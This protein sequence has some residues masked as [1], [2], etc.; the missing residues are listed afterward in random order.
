MPKRVPPKQ[1][2]NLPRYVA[3][4]TTPLK[5]PSLYSEEFR[6]M[7]NPDEA[8]RN[9]HLDYINSP[10]YKDRLRKQG[11]SDVNQVIHDRR[12]RVQNAVIVPQ[13][14]K[15][16]GSAYKS[17]L[18][19]I[20]IDPDQV[21]DL[22]T[23]RDDVL[24]HEMG[25]VTNSSVN[26][27]FDPNYR[28]LTTPSNTSL[29]RGE[30]EYI[31]L[32]NKNV[33]PRLLYAARESADKHNKTISD[34]LSD[35]R[36]DSSPYESK[37]DMDAL[38]YI[39]KQE[40]LY[41][42]G[43][44]DFTPEI[45]KKAKKNKAVKKS[46]NSKRLFNNFSDEDLIDIMNNVAYNNN[47]QSTMA[48][49]G[50]K[51]PLGG[52]LPYG[53]GDPPTDS[54][55]NKKPIIGAVD[56]YG[57]VI[58][59]PN[60][61]KTGTALNNEV[62]D[63]ARLRYIQQLSHKYGVPTNKIYSKRAR[64]YDDAYQDVDNKY[65][66]YELQDPNTQKWIT[67]RQNF[68]DKNVGYP[69]GAYRTPYNVNRRNGGK[70]PSYNY[71]GQ[72]CGPL[73]GIAHLSEIPANHIARDGGIIPA[74]YARDGIHI[75][76]ENRGK[77]TASAHKAGMSVQEFANHV[78]R[79]K[80]KYSST[81][82]KR[83]NFA[84][85]ASKWH[86]AEFGTDIPYMGIR[87]IDDNLQ[88]AKQRISNYF[89][90]DP[91]AGYVPNDASL[92]GPDPYKEQYMT[93]DQGD[94]VPSDYTPLGSLPDSDPQPYDPPQ[95]G[96]DIPSFTINAGAAITGLAGIVTKAAKRSQMTDEFSR[97][98]RRNATMQTYNPN[99]YGTGSQALMRNGGYVNSTF[100]Q[101]TPEQTTF[102][103]KQ[104]YKL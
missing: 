71:G 100:Y 40:N 47:T 94:V 35:L 72:L 80:G 64:R 79:N 52:L 7:Y 102:L 76:K 48:K 89:Q 86:K 28:V 3:A 50:K 77:F 2:V 65:M 26:T 62:Q 99:A 92:Q 23:T 39:L 30:E 91:Y 21:S 53:P 22:E 17:G 32:R 45:L 10:K 12:E 82:V 51:M 60:M 87:P 84:R 33:G 41:D 19:K 38:R 8:V 63:Q 73:D 18:N 97:L 83:A 54:T 57:N 13:P 36:H 96:M 67:L 90:N 55:L 15:E 43:R 5:N 56:I 69:V 46:Y 104:G 98:K 42:A 75:K 24:A 49:Y 70:V 16:I 4:N 6:R 31:G 85:N 11:Y 9:W 37:S 29:S 103:K 88:N 78:L 58:N 68:D 27:Q 74:D 66:E 101:F 25:H 14:D 81:Q 44:Q 61:T 20:F 93:N 95:G 59:T 1:R 34:V